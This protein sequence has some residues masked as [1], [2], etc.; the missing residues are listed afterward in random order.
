M[1]RQRERKIPSLY[2]TLEQVPDTRQSQGKR[3][4]LAAMLSL[5]CVALLCGRQTILGIS[6]WVS[7]YGKPYLRPFG[8]TYP[9]PPGQATWY[10]V[11]GGIDWAELE[12]GTYAWAQQVLRVLADNS[13]L[14]GVA[15]DGKTLR[16][17]KKQG[18]E[19]V[20][21]LSAVGHQ[22]AVTLAQ[23]AVG[24]KT[25]EIPMV[26]ELLGHLVVEGHVFT[27][28]ALLT[29]REIAKTILARKGDYLFVVKNNQ[30]SL[31]EDI[32]LLFTA[33][34]PRVRGDVWPTAKTKDLGHGRIETRWLQASTALND[35]LD[36]PGVQQV[37]QLV[38]Q[39]TDKKRGTSTTETIYGITSLSP[40]QASADQ[41][42]TLARQHW[43]IENQVHWVRDVVFAEDL[44]Q[45]RRGH[46]PH[47]MT[48]LRNAVISLL[49]ANGIEHIAR[50]R[51]RFAA[52]PDEALHLLGLHI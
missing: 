38:R 1:P 26:V 32:E 23:I 49:H 15:V 40:T 13:I 51:R 7:D 30:P 29:Q 10:R 18:A 52:R 33:P 36:W 45:T 22:L 5:A 20:H 17:S 3:H 39:R 14:Q 25:N 28:D 16:G 27:M 8:F 2:A 46:L 35:Y 9:E 37:F 41:L 34:P 19:D 6:D 21:L 48:T 11:L 44:A 47:I 31:R 50:A 43:T 4:P 12:A 42:L 24:D